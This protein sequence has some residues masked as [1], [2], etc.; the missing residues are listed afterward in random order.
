MINHNLE[1]DEHLLDLDPDRNYYNN[2]ISENQTF[3]KFNS[4]DSFLEGDSVLMHDENFLTIFSQNIRSLNC[5]LDSF[6]CLFPENKMPDVL[7]LSETST[8]DAVIMLVERAYHCSNE[9]DGSF[10]V[11]V[12]A[13]FMKSFDTIDHGILFDKLV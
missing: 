13:D 5:N 9:S 1:I 11:N 7:I 4:I 3:L 8:Q 10:F 12:F 2:V 6:L